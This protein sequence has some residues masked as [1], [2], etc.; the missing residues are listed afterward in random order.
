MDNKRGT[1]GEWG[2]YE[3]I[4]RTHKNGLGGRTRENGDLLAW[5]F[6][7]KVGWDRED[8]WE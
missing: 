7:E 6:S 4:G 2:G 5:L 3:R 1:V 8:T